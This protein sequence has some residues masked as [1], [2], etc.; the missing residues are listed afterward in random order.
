MKSITYSDLLYIHEKTIVAHGGSKGIRDA[1]LIKS[2]LELSLSTFGGEELYKTIEE[3]ISV[4]SYSLIK[5]HGFIDGNKRVGIV[6]L[7]LLCKINNINLKY[8]QNELTNLGLGV[9]AGNIDKEQIKAWIL[10]HKI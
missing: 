1:E 9:A 4:T 7:R 10:D 3:K 8:T 2:A 5:N 6:A